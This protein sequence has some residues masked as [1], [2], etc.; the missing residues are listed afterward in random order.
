MGDLASL[1][2]GLAADYRRKEAEGAYNTPVPQSQQDAFQAWRGALPMQLR[3]SQDYDLQGAFMGGAS[4][5]GEHMTDRWKKP[6]HMTFS[7][8]SQYSTPAQ[9]GGKWVEG[10]KGWTFWPTPFNMTQ[11]TPAEMAS[12][13]GSPAEPNGTVVLPITYKL[14]IGAR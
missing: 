3:G 11:H 4:P 7:N 10:D 6:N 9:P 14:P 12:Y 1:L 2:S 8:G 5:S 13:F